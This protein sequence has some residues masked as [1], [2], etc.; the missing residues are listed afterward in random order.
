MQVILCFTQGMIWTLALNGWRH[1][2]RSAKF[3]GQSVGARI[4]RW[5]WG[6]NNWKIPNA[7]SKLRNPQLARNVS[8]VSVAFLEV[9]HPRNASHIRKADRCCSITR[10]NSQV[11]L[12]INSIGWSIASASSV[13]ND[14]PSHTQI[15]AMS[16]D[17]IRSCRL[18]SRRGTRATRSSF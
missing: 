18:N 11:L 16:S 14:Q 1:W 8:E 10:E 17:M 3:S 4:R 2:N 7:K 5:W 15:R 9:G 12:R 6:V 13:A